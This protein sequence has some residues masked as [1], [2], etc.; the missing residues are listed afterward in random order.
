MLQ[1]CL[2]T[3]NDRATRQSHDALR[4]G[5]GLR[6]HLLL[7]GPD[8]RQ[9][10]PAN[11]TAAL[12]GSHDRKLAVTVRRPVP[13]YVLVLELIAFVARWESTR[14]GTNVILCKTR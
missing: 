1:H 9:S 7:G 14:Y 5:L 6:F 2:G 12:S 4:P 11:V 3:G 13:L 8:H 10:K